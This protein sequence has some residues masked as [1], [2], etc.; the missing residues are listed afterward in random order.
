MTSI[1]RANDVGG[2][3]DI[4]DGTNKSNE[5]SARQKNETNPIRKE[6]VNDGGKSRCVCLGAGYADCIQELVTMGGWAGLMF[7]GLTH[8]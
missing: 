4:G 7:H 1:I 3:H 6:K 5:E 2:Y 8:Y